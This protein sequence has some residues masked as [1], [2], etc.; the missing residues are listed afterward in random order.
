MLQDLPKFAYSRTKSL[1]D[2]FRV[3]LFGDCQQCHQPHRLYFEWFSGISSLKHARHMRELIRENNEQHFAGFRQ[4]GANAEAYSWKTKCDKVGLGA[5]VMNTRDSAVNL[6]LIEVQYLLC[7]CLS[8][9]YPKFNLQFFHY[10]LPNHHLSSCHWY[11]K[12]WLGRL[13]FFYYYCLCRP[14]FYCFK[15]ATTTLL[16]SGT[17]SLSLRRE[18]LYSY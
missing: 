6:H 11:C 4:V 15:S 16:R 18:L 3:Q 2:P 7:P 5:A 9:S 12:A 8:S 1:I 17:P 13:V 10:A 14:F